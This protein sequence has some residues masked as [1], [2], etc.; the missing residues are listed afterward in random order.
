MSEANP[1]FEPVGWQ[2]RSKGSFER[3]TIRHPEKKESHAMLFTPWLRSLK[4]S[5]RLTHKGHIRRKR[6]SVS[7]FAIENLEDRTLLSAPT[8]IS[9][10]PI[11]ATHS[12]LVST[13]VSA[14]FDQTVD[15]GTLSDQTFVVHA[16]QSRRLLSANGDITSLITSGATVTLNPANDFHPGELVL[17]TATAGIENAGISNIAT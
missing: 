8:V 13:D 11:N 17:V 10:S 16:M 9:T 4:F 5:V 3:I 12:A 14:T 7:L 15:M 1:Q 6:R 2:V